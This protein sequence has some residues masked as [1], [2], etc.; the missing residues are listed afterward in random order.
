MNCAA[1]RRLRS[2]A[3]VRTRSVMASR[4]L[5][6][7]TIHPRA[8]QGRPKPCHLRHRRGR[9]LEAAINGSLEPAGPEQWN[10]AAGSRLSC[11]P[12]P[13]GSGNPMAGGV[14]QGQYP[15]MLIP[16]QSHHQGADVASTTSSPPP[17]SSTATPAP[18]GLL[19]P[20]RLLPLPDN[21]RRVRRR[22]LRDG[23]DRAGGRRS[24]AAHPP[25]RGRNV[26]RA[27]GRGASSCSA[28]ARQGDGGRLRQRPARHRTP[29][30]Q[31]QRRRAPG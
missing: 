2:G 26:L 25:Q 15:A 12:H 13:R 14:P 8:A 9:S 18:R 29:L 10:L 30:P 5:M 27:R 31:R 28:T 20:R 4:T 7:A 23:G 24:A 19:G 1:S 11:C 6:D 3:I 16:Q 22:V 17:R 21:G